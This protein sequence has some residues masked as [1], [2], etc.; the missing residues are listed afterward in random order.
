MRRVIA[1]GTPPDQI[2]ASIST[3]VSRLDPAQSWQISIEAFKPKRSDQQNAFLWGVVYPSILEG[4]GES[5]RGWTTTDLHEYFLIEA[6]GSE[7]IEG[8]GRKRHKPI[9]RSSKLTKQEFSDYLAL[10]EA[11]CAELGIHIPEPSY[12]QA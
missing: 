3:M 4:G 9:R 6:F 8:F 12:E 10:I 11:K 2:A 1:R 5:L 7:V